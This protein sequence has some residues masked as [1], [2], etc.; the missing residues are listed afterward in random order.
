MTLETLFYVLGIVTML[1]WLIIL[2][3]V[4]VFLVRIRKA[5]SNLDRYRRIDFLLGKLGRMFS[6]R[7]G[8]DK[9]QQ[10]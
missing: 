5:V 3:F 4:L 6:W 8:A 2:V 7:G 10:K 9:W 1:S